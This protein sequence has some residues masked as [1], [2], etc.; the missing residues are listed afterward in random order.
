MIDA[1]KRAFTAHQ[2]VSIQTTSA[3]AHVCVRMCGYSVCLITGAVD[4]GETESS[5]QPV[6]RLGG[7]SV[8]AVPGAAGFGA[9]EGGRHRS[10]GAAAGGAG[11]A[12]ACEDFHKSNKFG[13]IGW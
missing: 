12:H 7:A 13:A 1:E 5:R 8:P 4:G 9:G 10:V 3:C 2:Q 11:K 6:R